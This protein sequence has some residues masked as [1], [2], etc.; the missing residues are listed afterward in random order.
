[1][2]IPFTTAFHHMPTPAFIAQIQSGDIVAANERLESLY[3]NVG[4]A[5]QDT[6]CSLVNDD[7][8]NLADIVAKLKHG[9]VER[10]SARLEV[11][12]RFLTAEISLVELD[13]EHVLGYISHTEHLDFSVAENTLL[14][15]ALTESSAGIWM[16]E[17]EEDTI[18]C[19]QSIA[20]LLGCSL[21]DT[22]HS[23]QA[24]RSRVHK[25]DLPKMQRTVEEHVKHKQRYYESEYR[26]RRGN[27]EYIWIRE[28]GR[29]YSQGPNAEVAK[30]IGF[31]EDISSQKA[32]EEH[33]RSQATFDELTGLLNRG[34][35]LTHFTKQLGLARRQYTPLT[36]AKIDLDARGLLAD[37][38]LEKRNTAIHTTA[39]FIYKKI[40]EADI[41]ARVAQDK[42]LLLLPNTSLRDAQKLIKGFLNPSEEE[43][44]VLEFSD[45]S[46]LNLCVGLATFPEDGETI[47]ELAQSA[48]SAVE[49]GR[50]AGI[51]ISIAE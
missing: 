19:S 40:R 15:F 1:M 50:T 21:E 41:L 10:I 32:L 22:P 17:V 31:I 44:K 26:I 23:S 8:S 2:S 11:G 38:P 30:V 46:H 5:R 7:Q 36:M 43:Q 3:L 29:T 6:W 42:L 51:A 49:K 33:L 14:K 48:N 27:D 18:S 4:A 16:W 35:A 24:W 39:R 37:M 34:A 47:E 45:A 20:S 9:E 12:D 13:D 28:R 25:D